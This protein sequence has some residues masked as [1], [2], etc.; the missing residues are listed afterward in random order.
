MVSKELTQLMMQ[1]L[2][3][4]VHNHRRPFSSCSSPIIVPSTPHNQQ[5]VRFVVNK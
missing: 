5:N 4:D 2:A 3:A 1:M